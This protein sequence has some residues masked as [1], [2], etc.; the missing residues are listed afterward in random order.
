MPPR[1]RPMAPEQRL[2]Q[3]V[4]TTLLLLREHGRDVTT[5][6]IA[7]AAGVAEGTIFRVVDSKEELVEAA[8]DRAFAPGA[9]VE[10]MLEIDA[11][12]PLRERLV[13]MV[14]IF[15]QRFRATF[16]LMRKVGLVRPPRH[17]GP[18]ADA[19]R[20]RLAALMAGVVGA[21][22]DRLTVP[23]DEFCH[24]LRLLAFSGAHPLISDGHYVGPEDVVDTV[25]DGLCRHD[26]KGIR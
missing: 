22:A 13:L 9:L 12:L 21:D 16:D 3:L 7:E 8:I 24:R 19:V 1:A 17:D 14:S 5:R 10:R 20:A 6:Q 18:E 23:V 11:D 4:D 25:L 2:D 15:Q 26:C